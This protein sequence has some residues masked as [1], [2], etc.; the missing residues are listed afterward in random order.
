MEENTQTPTEFELLEQRSQLLQKPGKEIQAFLV[1]NEPLYRLLMQRAQ[2]CV[3]EGLLLD[4]TKK[5]AI[6]E[7][8]GASAFIEYQYQKAPRADAS[9]LTPKMCQLIHMSILAV[10]EATELLHA[11]LNMIALRINEPNEEILK[12]IV[13]ELGDLDFSIAGVQGLLGLNR[14]EILK[15][16][17]EKLE[18]RYPEGIYTNKAAQIRADKP[19]EQNDTAPESDPDEDY[20]AD[21]A[22]AAEAA[23]GELGAEE[24]PDQ[25]VEASDEPD[26]CGCAAACS[27]S[28]N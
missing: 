3:I 9:A 24:T 4:A 22:T 18:L 23:Q 6:Y 16:N 12:N 13:E 11:V 14:E 15:V 1:D 5:V 26:L 8:D 27:S 7:K 25:A 10:G 21:V 28:G 20:F 17:R 2:S 19:E